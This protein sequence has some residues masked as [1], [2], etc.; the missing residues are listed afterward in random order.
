VRGWQ[1]RQA[2]REDW[3]EDLYS[4]VRELI[5]THGTAP[6][7]IR[8]WVT[9]TIGGKVPAAIKNRVDT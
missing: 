1:L 5:E 7:E 8:R 2:T 6:R 4:A 3:I 9:Q